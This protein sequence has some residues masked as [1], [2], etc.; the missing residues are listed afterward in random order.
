M[1][2]SYT[3]QS[4]RTSIIRNI[5]CLFVIIL[6]D[7]NHNIVCLLPVISKQSQLSIMSSR[8]R[9]RSRRGER[10]SSSK[11]TQPYHNGFKFLILSSCVCLF[12]LHDHVSVS[13]SGMDTTIFDVPT[14]LQTTAVVA[15]SNAALSLSSSSSELHASL[16]YRSDTEGVDLDSDLSAAAASSSIEEAISVLPQE[17][18]LL[19]D[20]KPVTMAT[21]TATATAM[22]TNMTNR[23]PKIVF[24]ML[25]TTSGNLPSYTELY[26]NAK[27]H[28]DY[29][30][31]ATMTTHAMETNTTTTTTTTNS[32]SLLEAHQSWSRHNPDYEIR[33]YDLKAG[34]RYLQQY[35]HPLFLRTFDCLQAFG[36][37]SDFLRMAFLYREG[38]Y[39]SDWKEVCLQ[40]NLLNRLSTVAAEF[41]NGIVL[42]EDQW[43]PGYELLQHTT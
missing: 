15:T 35:F 10:D 42:F 36:F 39:Y 11:R 30:L 29:D 25:L 28:R 24:K 6:L 32:Q 34:R 37:K 23:I 26:A 13:F 19:V 12:K 7:H 3:V 8:R 17:E 43:S 16:P 21:A 33:Y 2:R 41:T 18:W 40:P 22:V 27:E 9:H 14:F 31:P 1:S 4:P 20:K 38:G 5:P